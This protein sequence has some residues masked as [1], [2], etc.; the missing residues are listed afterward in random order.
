[1]TSL[2]TLR[3]NYKEQLKDI[4]QYAAYLELGKL[5]AKASDALG[6]PAGTDGPSPAHDVLFALA[7]AQS[8][9]ADHLAT[10]PEYGALLAIDKLIDDLNVI[11]RPAE[12]ASEPESV[13]EPAV[14]TAETVEVASAEVPGTNVSYASPVDEA[15]SEVGSLSGLPTGEIEPDAVAETAAV[16]AE[17]PAYGGFA[18]TP[19]PAAETSA[20]P[21]TIVAYDTPAAET[22]G[23]ERAA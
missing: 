3:D 2:K 16:P 12:V 23:A 21:T 5:T 11:L 8:K 9:F 19:Q 22:T 14:E 7:Q 13:S 1:M 15:L 17:E 10:V 6:I 4:P 18:H 20:V